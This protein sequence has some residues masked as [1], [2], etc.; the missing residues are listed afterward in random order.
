MFHLE[1]KEKKAAELASVESEKNVLSKEEAE[2][3]KRNQRSM[4][5]S[6]KSPRSTG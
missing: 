6:K 1:G 5:S 2:I 3:L 4:N